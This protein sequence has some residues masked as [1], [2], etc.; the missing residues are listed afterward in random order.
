MSDVYRARDSRLDRT[1]VIK[2]LPTEVAGDAECRARF[3]RE[4]KAV[5]RSTIRTS[6]ASSM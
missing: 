6:A 1:V 2:V 5:T 3:E 4:A